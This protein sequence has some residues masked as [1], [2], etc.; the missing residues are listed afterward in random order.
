MNFFIFLSSNEPEKL[1]ENPSDREGAFD[2][3]AP[4]KIDYK[5]I[6]Q[7]VSQIKGTKNW[8]V[9]IPLVI[10]GTTGFPEDK[11]DLAIKNG[12]AMFQVGT[13]IKKKYPKKTLIIGIIK[14]PKLASII[15]FVATA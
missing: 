8:F 9:E 10:H 12:V 4:Q 7:K 6:L 2:T 13:I 5:Y 3:G 14:Y 1:V 15:L 11:I